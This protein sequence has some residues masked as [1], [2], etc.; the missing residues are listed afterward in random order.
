MADDQVGRPSSAVSPS[1]RPTSPLTGPLDVCP[2]RPRRK[3]FLFTGPVPPLVGTTCEVEGT[4]GQVRNTHTLSLL[5]GPVSS[6]SSDPG[7]R[8]E[9]GRPSP[10]VRSPPTLPECTDEDS[11]G[12]DYG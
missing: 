11:V 6:T 12:T 8:V 3:C 4:T 1:L 10:P 9:A 5:P 2:H 7:V